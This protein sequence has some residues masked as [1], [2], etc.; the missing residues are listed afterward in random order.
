MGYEVERIEDLART[1]TMNDKKIANLLARIH[2][3]EE[4]QKG[5]EELIIFLLEKEAT[6][7]DPLRWRQ[8]EMP[9]A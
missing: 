3:L 5:M 9:Q 1:I 4:S 6:T 7:R 2:L 8:T